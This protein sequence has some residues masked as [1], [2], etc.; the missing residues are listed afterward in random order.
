MIAFFQPEFLNGVEFLT[1]EDSNH[2]IRVLRQ[3]VGDNIEI[4]NGKGAKAVVEIIDANP[5]K[6]QFRI[7]NKEIIPQRSYSI[8]LA[9]AA[10]K[11][12]ERLEWCIEKCTEIGVKK[13]TIINCRHSERIKIRE[14]RLLKKIASAVKQSHNPFLPELKAILPFT[15]LISSSSEDERFICYVD[16]LQPNHLYNLATPNKSYCVV[17]G[18]E[19]DFTQDEI[20]LA[21]ENDFQKVSLSANTLRTETA[22][23]YAVSALNLIN[24]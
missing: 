21:E 20:R 7:V 1:E 10:T 12:H 4:L 14:T 3:T 19:G 17:I 24:R 13:I 9:I 22:G 6:V 23:V 5:V 8:H 16:K 11:N 2:C 15:Q 18:P